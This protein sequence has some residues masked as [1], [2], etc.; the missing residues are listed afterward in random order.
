VA[1]V[2]LDLERGVV[3]GEEGRGFGAANLWVSLG[4]SM[5]SYWTKCPAIQKNA[6]VNDAEVQFSSMRLFGVQ[7]Q[8]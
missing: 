4:T 7:S 2:F 1:D 5:S 6:M 3:G 8:F